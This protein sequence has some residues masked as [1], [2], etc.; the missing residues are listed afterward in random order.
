MFKKIGHCISKNRRQN[1]N[2]S[3]HQKFDKEGSDLNSA[4]SLVEFFKAKQG[5]NV[6]KCDLSNLENLLIDY[7]IVKCKLK[8]GEIQDTKTLNLLRNKN[9]CCRLKKFVA[10]SRAWVYFE[11]QIL[12]LL[13]VFLSNSQLVVQQ[14][15]SC[16]ATS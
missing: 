11:Q 14:I 4:L 5:Q 8:G 7:F 9:I 16:C 15:C 2:N 13:L 10:K 6:P 3:C 1:L 12:A